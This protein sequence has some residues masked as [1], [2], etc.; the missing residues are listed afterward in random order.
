[1]PVDRERSDT[2]ITVPGI[3]HLEVEGIEKETEDCSWELEEVQQRYPYLHSLLEVERERRP[4]IIVPSITKVCKLR[5]DLNG[6][7]ERV[8]QLWRISCKQVMFHDDLIVEKDVEIVRLKQKRSSEGSSIG[9]S[10]S[11]PTLV[12]PSHVEIICQSVLSTCK[13]FTRG[14]NP[15]TE[16][17]TGEN[18]ET[19]VDDW[20]PSLKRAA[21]VPLQLAGRLLGRV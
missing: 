8:K 9:P 10:I 17:F 4:L 15:T 12:D 11:E 1:M 18:L 5:E 16:S 19:A 6:E 14:E 20:L 3:Q 13:S 2:V 21:T 7:K